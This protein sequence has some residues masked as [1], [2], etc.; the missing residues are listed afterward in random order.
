[1]TARLVVLASGS[2]TNCQAI[3]DAC[4][5]GRLDAE[6]V[7]VVTNNPDAGVIARARAAGA[8]VDIVDHSGRS[9]ERRAECDRNLIEVIASHRPD[10]VVLAGWMRILGAELGATFAMIN[11][12]PAKP[13]E[14]AG[15]H[16]I[17][18]A[19]D[20][21]QAGH[22]A[23][24]GVMVHWIPDGG[25]DDGPVIV[26]ATLGFEPGES[27][28]DFE[29]RLHVLEHILIVDGVRAALAQIGLG[30]GRIPKP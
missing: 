1:M 15:L 5:R 24:S 11:L 26:T 2:G 16:A 3:I 14:F 23:E 29:A 12:H 10:L 22:I 9:P 8:A 7:A 28:A 17:D 4:Q 6:V 18:R 20:A 25:V 27:L 19:Y 21:W 30:S 13:G